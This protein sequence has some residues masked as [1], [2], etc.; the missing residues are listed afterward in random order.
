MACIDCDKAQLLDENQLELVF[1]TYVRVGPANI[2]VS[3]CQKHLQ[4]LFAQLRDTKVFDIE[5]GDKYT[6]MGEQVTGVN[7]VIEHTVDTGVEDG[8]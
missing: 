4:Q 1:Y 5:A 6:I 3:G 7:T 8:R 2:L